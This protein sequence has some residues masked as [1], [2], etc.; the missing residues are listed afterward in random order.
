[1]LDGS[2]R[3]KNREQVERILKEAIR[4]NLRRD[5]IIMAVGGGVTLDV[6]GFAASIFRRGI[7]YLRV[8]TSLIGLVD[9]G[10]GIKQGI[11]AAGKKNSIG[12]YYPPLASINDITFLSTLPRRHLACGLAEIIKI[13]IVRDEGLFSLL[14][15][16]ALEL[17]DCRFQGHAAA[18]EVML[19]AEQL[20]MQE[21]QP[22][23][24][25]QTTRR[26]VDFGHTF[27]PL[28]ESATGYSMRHG[29]AVAIDMLLSTRIAVLRGLCPEN[30]QD[31]IAWL[32]RIV[33]LPPAAPACGPELLLEAIENARAHRGC[34][35]LVVPRGIGDADFLQD[36]SRRELEEAL[37]FATG[38][39]VQRAGHTR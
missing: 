15:R 16:H 3:E 33:G 39:Q 30:V 32:L 13:A 24:F 14:E 35:N 23:L 8:P 17:L 26:L 27:S 1:L 25:E 10:V 22:N 12:T 7:H 9:V 34:L 37:Q 18:R 19:R 6:A 38:R 31:R 5:G 20:M 2:E 29:E 36:V 21:L 4:V 28:I 11:N